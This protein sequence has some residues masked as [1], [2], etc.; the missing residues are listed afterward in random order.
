MTTLTTSNVT[1]GS[2]NAR[3]R[4]RLV[5]TLGSSGTDGDTYKVSWTL[6][7]DSAYQYG[8]KVT[9]TLSGAD[10]GSVSK[11]PSSG[12]MSSSWVSASKSGTYSVSKGHSSASKT[13]TIKASSSSTSTTK[14]KSVTFTVPAKTSYTV[15]FNANGGSGAPSS[16]TKWYGET[17]ALSTTK[18]TR[19]GYTFLGWSTSSTATSATY[20]AGGSYTSN[21]GVTLYAV[22]KENTYTVTY[23]G[24]GGSTPSS[25]TKKYFTNL[26]LNGI[27]T[28]DGYVFAGWSTSSTA[29]V[30]TYT[31]EQITNGTATYSTNA[32][33]TLYA[34]W[35]PAQ[36][37]VSFMPNGT[38]VENMPSN[39]TFDGLAGDSWP[40]NITFTTTP[41]RTF[42]NFVGWST[43]STAITA[44]YVLN[45]TYPFERE[46]TL[47]A[48][49]SH[50]TATQYFY[51]KTSTSEN[52]VITTQTV[53][54]DA[55]VTLPTASGVTNK[56]EF[57][58]W[59]TSA[60]YNEGKTNQSTLTAPVVVTYD[61]KK[62]DLT[63][64]IQ[65]VTLSDP[66][67]SSYNYYGVYRD[68]SPSKATLN[69]YET[70]RPLTNSIEVLND[71]ETYV[72]TV[73]NGND[74]PN[75]TMEYS[76]YIFGYL[77]LNSTVDLNID[78][79]E[80]TKN[81]GEDVLF[82][83]VA[84]SVISNNYYIF[85]IGGSSIDVNTSYILT[86]TGTAENGKPVE[87]VISVNISAQIIDITGPYEGKFL[88]S[89][90]ETD[91]HN[92]KVTFNSDV[93]IHDNLIG[94]LGVVDR[95]GDKKLVHQ[96]L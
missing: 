84:N 34:V 4:A 94:D 47:Y 52:I 82:S 80:L 71:F 86:L 70:I 50:Q 30:A 53:Y 24:N 63:Y 68:V 20:A 17:L 87:Y 57:L 61:T 73:K 23:N 38:K 88:N 16:Q 15:S 92:S 26:I 35:T 8:T 45:N 27:S 39:Q 76:N 56:Y 14:S 40:L 18:P 28:R 89:D 21:S 91:K 64:L 9:A 13:F 12:E 1:W 55:E 54:R 5:Y 46:T 58:G 32:V 62:S 3:G 66:A 79:K 78:N 96:Q 42:Y 31:A 75:T 90:E 69:S 33:T 43:S 49:W 83:E 25:Q 37:T 67:A 74:Y 19:T 48:V 59:T 29:T 72:N 41:K 36:F 93:Y 7:A 22:W 77:N 85:G 81:D 2:A 51:G 95:E 44:Q 10:S 11:T 6:Y 60:K 65:T